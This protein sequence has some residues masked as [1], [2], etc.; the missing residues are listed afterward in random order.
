M[1]LTY[2][3]CK[4]GKRNTNC[5][6]GDIVKCNKNSNNKCRLLV[7]DVHEMGLTFLNC[8]KDDDC[9]D[10][11][12]DHKACIT[13][14]GTL[15]YSSKCDDD[16]SDININNV[17]HINNN[18]LLVCGSDTKYPLWSYCIDKCGGIISC[19][20]Q[21]WNIFVNKKL[22]FVGKLFDGFAVIP[23]NS[24]QLIFFRENECDYKKVKFEGCN[25][26]SEKMIRT[27]LNYECINGANKKENFRFAGFF[28]KHNQI[29]YAVELSSDRKEKV[30]KLYILKSSF[31][32]GCHTLADDLCLTA[33]YNL[34]KLYKCHDI[35]RNDI[36]NMRVSSISHKNNEIFILTSTKSN[37]YLWN[38][39]IPVEPL[40]RNSCNN[41]KL[42]LVH[43]KKGKLCL[44]KKPRG[45]TFINNCEIFVVCD[46][47]KCNKKCETNYYLLNF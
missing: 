14:F 25:S 2:C 26:F 22:S 15:D 30:K 5:F 21:F 24:F 13:K 1:E 42:H 3:P 38:D 19:E 44:D 27:I 29:Y 47:G 11:P 20:P 28:V 4:G 9:C 41:H 46:H 43:G 33:V 35:D 36:H 39:S 16:C 7:N 32:C 10:K 8:K 40:C 6:P 45:I 18:R 37:G 17:C 23:K 31:R 34:H 12:L